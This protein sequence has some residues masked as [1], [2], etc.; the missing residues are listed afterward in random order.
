[1]AM[2]MMLTV[3]CTCKVVHGACRWCTDHNKEIAFGCWTAHQGWGIMA[4]QAA[5]GMPQLAGC[6]H[7]GTVTTLEVERVQV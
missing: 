6:N 2:D 7:W 1:M 3:W 5:E 4:R